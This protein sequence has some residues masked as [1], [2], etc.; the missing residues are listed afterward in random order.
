MFPKNTVCTY[1]GATPSTGDGIPFVIMTSEGT[2]ERIKTLLSANDYYG[3]NPKQIQLFQQ[4]NYNG[5]I[6]Y[7]YL[8]YPHLIFKKYISI[9]SGPYL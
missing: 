8:T 1:A 4:V 5:L 7:A 6:L 2:H 3:M 9:N